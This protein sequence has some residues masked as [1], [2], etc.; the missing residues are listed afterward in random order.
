M[1]PL[2]LSARS[3]QPGSSSGGGVFRSSSAG[4][5]AVAAHL[6]VAV[7]GSNAAAHSRS[8]SADA[9]SGAVDVDASLDGWAGEPAAPTT[10]TAAA[11]A[12]AA[13]AGGGSGS[14]RAAAVPAISSIHSLFG[15]ELR[16]GVLLLQLLDLLQPGS[17][18]WRAVNKP[19]FVSRT[20]QLKALENCQL[21]LKVAQVCFGSLGNKDLYFCLSDEH[22]CMHGAMLHA[23]CTTCAVMRL[24]W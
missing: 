23:C 15:A 16:S 17:I 24:E 3:S 13:S 11:A 1:S 19:P 4:A 10:P 12:A 6:N 22:W 8:I 5:A 18:D 20:A 7:P 14:S 2:Q 21:A 9:V